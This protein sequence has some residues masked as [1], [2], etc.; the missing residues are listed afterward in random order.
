MDLIVE[1]TT[2]IIPQRQRDSWEGE[3]KE[4][5][6]DSKS[7]EKVP[8]HY[9]WKLSIQVIRGVGVTKFAFKQY[10]RQ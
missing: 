2:A 6:S 4:I 7:K 9:K 10:M 1:S 3:K 5:K 8:A